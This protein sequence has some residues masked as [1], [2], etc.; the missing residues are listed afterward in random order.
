M[1]SRVRYWELEV[2]ILLI[3]MLFTGIVVYLFFA[4]NTLYAIELVYDLS[5]PVIVLFL[6]YQAMVLLVGFCFFRVAI[7]KN[8]STMELF[9]EVEDREDLS[10]YESLHLNPFEK[11]NM[12][13]K[14]K[15][16]EVCGVCRISRPVRSFHC[17]NCDRCF[18]LMYKHLALF[19]ICIGFTNYKFYVVFLFYSIWLCALGAGCFIHGVIHSLTSP[20]SRIVFVPMVV[21]VALQVVVLL[22]ALWE[23]YQAVVCILQNETLEERRQR[24]DTKI[25]YNIGKLANWQMIM[26]KKW[27]HWFL[28]IWSTSGNGL[29]FPYIQKDYIEIEGP[30]SGSEVGLVAE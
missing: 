23:L 26:G 24:K 29:E 30:D 19:D 9:P 2:V 5:V 25:S 12:Q 8:C 17:L 16:M 18:L 21:A 1:Q 6:I 20:N 15:S 22:G 7:A 4:F 13:I 11:D 3:K 14:Q 10:S 28:P 27:Y